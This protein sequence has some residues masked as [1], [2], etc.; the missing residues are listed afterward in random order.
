MSDGSPRSPLA[1]LR[2]RAAAAV[3][4][5]RDRCSRWQRRPRAAAPLPTA[6]AVLR[7]GRA[8]RLTRTRRLVTWRPPRLVCLPR[9]GA[10]SGD[11]RDCRADRTGADRA[12]CRARAS[13]R[14]CPGGRASRGA[15]AAS[16]FTGRAA[17]RPVPESGL[18][19]RPRPPAAV[20]PPRAEETRLRLD[21]SRSSAARSAA[22]ARAR[23][24]A[25]ERPIPAETRAVTPSVAE[26]PRPGG[27]RPS[28]SR[29][30]KSRRSPAGPRGARRH[31][32]G[33]ART[34][35]AAPAHRRSEPRQLRSSAKGF[36]GRS[37]FLVE[38]AL[39]TFRDWRPNDEIYSAFAA[40]VMAATPSRRNRRPQAV[41]EARPCA[42]VRVSRCRVPT[43]R[44]VPTG[45]PRD[46]SDRPD[47]PDRRIVP[48]VR[49]AR[50]PGRGRA[51]ASHL[52][53]RSERGRERRFAR[54]GPS[55]GAGIQAASPPPLE[56]RARRLIPGSGGQLPGPPR[57]EHARRLPAN[58]AVRRHAWLLLRFQPRA[59]AM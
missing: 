44:I 5:F 15:R 59:E 42:A 30:P 1:A 23:I 4:R 48:T 43:A 36:G 49:I 26:G 47:R 13:R 21:P 14:S 56:R 31:A 28:G 8:S 20:P 6:Q 9:S 24:H 7:G 29:R 50:S 3:G 51:L 27:S 19:R 11:R 33:R 38:H 16:R 57:P 22:A 52:R 41:R 40:L 34:R 45:G 35:R 53:A 12:R 37:V 39:H 32:P 18:W 58:G 2:P 54:A 17:L 25:A 10:G 55:R 46:R